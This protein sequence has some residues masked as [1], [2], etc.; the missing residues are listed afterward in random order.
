MKKLALA[1]V[2]LTLLLSSCESAEP[3]KE[4]STP[5]FTINGELPD[6]G[7][8]SANKPQERFY[9]KYTPEFIPSDAYGEVIPFV[10]MYKDY[11]G[12]DEYSTG[13]CTPD[14]KIVMDAVFNISNIN[15]YKTSDGF[16]YYRVLFDPPKN[17]YSASTMIVHKSGEHCLMFDEYTR[18]YSI[19]GG[20]IVSGVYDGEASTL[21]FCDYYGNEL[22]TLDGLFCYGDFSHGLLPVSRLDDNT[23]YYID[24]EGNT[25]LGP[26]KYANSFNTEGNAHITDMNGDKY[27]IDIYGN[28]LTD[29]EYIDINR[30][31]DDIAHHYYATHK[32]N[33]RMIDVLDASGNYVATVSTGSF[34]HNGELLRRYTTTQN[35]INSYHIERVSDGVEI[36]S[37]EYGTSPDRDGIYGDLFVSTLSNGKV[38]FDINGETVAFI[39]PGYDFS[40]ISENRRYMVCQSGSIGYND[41]TGVYTDTRKTHVYDISQKATI[42]M[43]DGYSYASSV[44]KNDRYLLISYAH[45][46]SDSEYSL[47]DTETGEM[48]FENCELI[49]YR[50]FGNSDYFNVCTKNSSSLYDIDFNLI[51]RNYYE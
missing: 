4:V 18:I 45:N 41:R 7:E 19:E 48:I 25:V 50:T 2:L 11:S 17:M 13:F 32:N 49:S 31:D 21:N 6:I 34:F 23:Y 24:L 3:K 9:E 16:E 40:T 36:V 28:R 51:L 26:Y 44:G 39:K 1:L 33:Q 15:Y 27:I 42:Y 43:Y 30:T 35:G 46:I 8:F 29:T 5:V 37:K 38:I 14:G 20:V 12:V 10:G 47:L 22:F